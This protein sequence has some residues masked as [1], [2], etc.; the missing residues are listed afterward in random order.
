MPDAPRMRPAIKAGLR[1]PAEVTKAYMKQLLARREVYI[2]VSRSTTAALVRSRSRAQGGY[3]RM[4]VEVSKTSNPRI[5][6]PTDV[7][8]GP[9][10]TEDDFP[11]FVS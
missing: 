4:D 5:S 10:W 6:A 8:N 9:V 2:R 11:R 1:G 3:D 7:G